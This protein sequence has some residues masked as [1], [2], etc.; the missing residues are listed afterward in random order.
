MTPTFRPLTSAD[1][2]AAL[3]I[4]SAHDR[5]DGVAAEDA[6]A[7]SLTHQFALCIEDRLVGVT[8][9]SEIADTVGAWWLSW[10]YLDAAWRGRGLGKLMLGR[11]LDVMVEHGARKV[12]LTTSDLPGRDGKPKYGAAIRAYTAAGFEREARH[13]DFYTPGEAM[14]VMGL[15]LRPPDDRERSLDPRGIEVLD[16][17]EI[18]ETDDTYALDWRY[19]DGPGDSVEVLRD[20]VDDLRSLEARVVFLGLPSDTPLAHALAEAAGFHVDG[21]L[22]DFHD[23]GVHEVRWRLD[24]D[25]APP[26]TA[27]DG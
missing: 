25:D 17:E 12:F 15:R 6:Y 10:T 27:P 8:G 19:V 26:L 24:L 22:R 4:I 16:A 23:D 2:P 14:F 5:D 21:T 13:A 11:M 9:G 1:L 3:R 7:H 20:A 18:A